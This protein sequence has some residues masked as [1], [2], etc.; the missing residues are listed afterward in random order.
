MAGSRFASGVGSTYFKID[1]VRELLDELCPTVHSIIPAPGDE[2]LTDVASESVHPT[3]LE[4][5]SSYNWVYGPG[6]RL[7]IIVP[8]TWLL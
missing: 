8:G 6:K 5:V 1:A 3:N 2:D 7:K 4:T